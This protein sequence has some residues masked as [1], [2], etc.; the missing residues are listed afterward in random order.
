MDRN[1]TTG[2]VLVKIVVFDSPG[3]MQK[4]TKLPQIFATLNRWIHFSAYALVVIA[5]S[6]HAESSASL[7]LPDATSKTATPEITGDTHIQTVAAKTIFAPTQNIW[8]TAALLLTA[9]GLY[10]VFKR[11]HNN[12]HQRNKIPYPES[13]WPQVLDMLDE[14]IVLVDHNDMIVRGNQ[15]F[16]QSTGKTHG[17]LVGAP[18]SRYC[19]AANEHSCPL[20]EARRRGNDTTLT[21]EAGTPSNADTR[22]ME[23]HFH[24]VHDSMGNP[25][26]VFQHS[27]ALPSLSEQQKQLR[28]S[29]AQFRA[30]LNSTPDP[31]VI[32]NQEG[33]IIL[34]NQQC[35]SVFGY[36]QEQLLGE[37]V[38]ILVPQSSR[39]E[40][41]TMRQ[42]F[43]QQPSMRPLGNGQQL[44]AQHRNGEIIP[45]DISLS[46]VTIE[47]ELYI[48]AVV[49]DVSE[50]KRYEWELKRLASFPHL[51]PMP[52]IEV[53]CGTPSTRKI[54][55]LNPQAEFLFPDLVEK[56][57]KH[58]ILAGLD[59]HLTLAKQ[60]GKPQTR[61]VET[62]DKVYEQQICYVDEVDVAHISLWDVTAMY[63][64]TNEMTYQASH[65]SLT[66]LFN[67]SEFDRRIRVALANAESQGT[68][69][70]LCYVDLD[71]FKIVNDQC[72]HA[73]GDALLKQLAKIIKSKIRATDT[74][75]RLGGDEFGLLLENCEAKRALE[76]LENIL[77]NIE[78]YRFIWEQKSFS[79]GASI[80]LVMITEHS[81]AISHIMQ[82]ADSACYVAKNEG[83][84]RIHMYQPDDEALTQHTRIIQWA[85]KLQTALETN[86]FKLFA[87]SIH[88]LHN[89]TD[90]LHE[91]LVRMVDEEDKIIP[92]ANFI[93]A[94]ERYHL[95]QSIDRWVIQQTF[96]VIEKGWL[97]GS[98]CTIN[99]SGD[100]IGDATM[101]GFV[102]DM[103]S[104]HG[105]DPQYICF[106]ITETAMVTN[107][108]QTRHFISA[109]KELGCKFALDDF[110]SGVSSFA[111]LQNLPV[112]ILKIDG[113]LVRDIAHNE[114]SE[115]MVSSINTIGHAMQMK[116]I[117]EFVENDDIVK[118]LTLLDVDFGQ[119]YYFSKPRPVD[120]HYLMPLADDF[121]RKF[122]G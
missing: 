122:A 29:E 59:R 33:K 117:A 12:P 73:A 70:V 111:Y 97:K 8:L 85:H 92:P 60:T 66:G 27:R 5:C 106:E 119:G 43:T 44:Q 74:L 82:A 91:V 76:I 38:E 32:C 15:A 89:P 35:V 112:D 26:G 36:T 10:L 95:I 115:V 54:S 57:T 102:M 58:K 45:V 18:A 61:V 104:E 68:Q 96:K 114:I 93:P 84:G 90:I 48:I 2:I 81:G 83:G 65:D 78:Q 108:V 47:G 46:P 24:A 113:A 71:R 39:H 14:P 99:L 88:S 30:L 56:G 31:L 19:H 52:I 50:Q 118:K 94:A 101:L 9:V 116:T 72:G 1:K 7:W 51:N 69:H 109:L 28:K 77:Q 42:T 87:Q 120:E 23:V 53:K 75:A 41:V 37:M 17:E 4:T 86:R 55:Y 13:Q 67:R 3:I 121:P 40:H 6:Y 110:G 64:L 11:W 107:L 98:L 62:D 25:I 22:A 16:Y 63:R 79:V 49:R 103:F 100:T 21:L 105:I 20:C 80:G 34:A